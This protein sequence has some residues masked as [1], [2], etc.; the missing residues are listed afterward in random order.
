MPNKE[1]LVH[2]CGRKDIVEEEIVDA[3][4]TLKTTKLKITVCSGCFERLE[5]M[6]GVDNVTGMR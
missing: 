6:Y 4:V 3:T 1:T 2:C 5:N